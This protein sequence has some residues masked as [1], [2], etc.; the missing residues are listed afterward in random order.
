MCSNKLA[1]QFSQTFKKHN[2][3]KVFGL[4]VVILMRLGNNNHSGGFKV[5]GQVPKVTMSLASWRNCAWKMSSVRNIL[6]NDHDMCDGPGVDATEQVDRASLSS[7]SEK[8]A[9]GLRGCVG[10]DARKG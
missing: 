2:R 8:G 4:S 6:S 10:K 1:D 9:K 7:V 5:G 3:V